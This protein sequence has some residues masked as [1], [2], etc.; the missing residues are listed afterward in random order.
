[1]KPPLVRPLR[2]PGVSADLESFA[3]SVTAPSSLLGF[4]GFCPH[5][6]V[7][8]GHQWPRAAI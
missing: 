6:T 5:H 7:R 2:G 3:V 1:M 8:H 4:L